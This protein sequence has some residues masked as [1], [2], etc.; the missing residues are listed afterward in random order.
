MKRIII[1]V[2]AIVLVIGLAGCGSTKAEYD[3]ISA[4]L[5]GEWIKTE[6][7]GGVIYAKKGG[8]GVFSIRVSD[9]YLRDIDRSIE[10]SLESRT[11]KNGESDFGEIDG[12]SVRIARGESPTAENVSKPLYGYFIAALFA[13]DGKV[14][15][16]SYNVY[17]DTEAEIPDAKE[18]CEKGFD[19]V[20]GTIKI[21]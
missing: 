21:E 1:F 2:C 5:K 6:S 16:I 17:V 13:R 20:S 12:H 18:A 9:P 14:V 11:E 3:G 19:E 10:I 7:Q 15:E 4:N 8:G